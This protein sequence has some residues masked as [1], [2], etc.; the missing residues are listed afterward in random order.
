MRSGAC[1]GSPDAPAE[2]R[3]ELRELAREVRLA[4]L[5]VEPLQRARG[6]RQP[7]GR[8][9]DTEIDAARRERG[10][11]LEGF[12]DLERAVVLQHHAAR[13]DADARRVREEVR[14]DDL[15]R[16]ACKGRRAVMFGDPEALV[17]EL[18]GA[19][20]ERRGEAQR[21]GGV[22]AVGDR[23]LVQQRKRIRHGG[24]RSCVSVNGR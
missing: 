3:V 22:R 13:A 2:K 15:R 14:D 8:L 1:G 12:G 4:R 20:R 5:V 10:Q 24:R 18:F 23:T 21:V 16:R 9:A 17:A 11:H 7:A 6:Q 19:L